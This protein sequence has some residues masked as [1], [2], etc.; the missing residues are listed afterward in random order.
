MAFT[1]KVSLLWGQGS[2]QI[3]T[4][5]A[6][7]GD[8]EQN[9]S[10]ALGTVT[11]QA[12]D[13]AWAP[14]KLVSIFITT[15]VDCTLKLN[16]SGSP[17]DTITLKAGEPFSWLKNSGVA[18]PFVGSTGTVT[19]GYITTTAATNVEIRTLLAL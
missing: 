5:F 13:M 10:L 17:T 14:A 2:D 7:T 12:L 16:S 3:G 18:Y 9:F 6:P 15:D 19:A 4:Q 1:H 8:L 11:N